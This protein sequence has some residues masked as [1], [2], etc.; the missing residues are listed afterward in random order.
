M[1]YHFNEG[2]MKAYRFKTTI[3]D[4]G[5]IHLPN[6]PA[7]HNKEVEIII[8]TPSKY[9]ESN[10]KASDFIFKWSGFL[11]E[12]DIDQDKLNYLLEKYR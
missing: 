11:S 9:S 2:I 12:T 4:N 7:L 1:L 5:T 8:I 3:S 6:N 10:N